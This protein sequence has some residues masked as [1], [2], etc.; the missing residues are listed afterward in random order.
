MLFYKSCNGSVKTLSAA[1]V[2]LTV[3]FIF[4]NNVRLISLTDSLSETS[5]PLRVYSTETHFRYYL[6]QLPPSYNVDV[7]RSSNVEAYKGQHTV[8]ALIHRR[9]NTSTPFSLFDGHVVVSRYN[10]EHHYSTNC[11]QNTRCRKCWYFC[12]PSVFEVYCCQVQQEAPSPWGAVAAT[13][14]TSSKWRS[15]LGQVE[16]LVLPRE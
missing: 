5:F 3:V 7:L 15:I 9:L 11:G 2:L 4:W 1:S 14:W 12:R 16:A 13:C 8:A 6:Y 10:L